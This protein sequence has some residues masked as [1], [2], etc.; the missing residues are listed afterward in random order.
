[1]EQRDGEDR[2]TQAIV[3]LASP[4]GRYGYSRMTALLRQAGWKVGKNRVPCIWRREGLEIPAKH[5]PRGRLWPNDGSCI[6]LQ[7]ER[8]NHVW[9]YDFV[10]ARTNDR[11]SLRLLTMI[12]EFTR[13]CP[14]IR[15]ARRLNSST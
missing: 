2:L 3:A 8:R 11:R 15:V 6:R 9:N 14:A 1:L 5:K 4:H 12:D 7:P 10:E 13:E